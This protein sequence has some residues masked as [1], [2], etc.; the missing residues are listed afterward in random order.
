MRGPGA[1]C[2]SPWRS[3]SI[4]SIAQP[5]LR[6]APLDGPR[7]RDGCSR[8]SRRKRGVHLAKEHQPLPAAAAANHAAPATC[9][10]TSAR[11]ARARCGCASTQRIAAEARWTCSGTC[12]WWSAGHRRRGMRQ[13]NRRR[14]VKTVTTGESPPA[15]V[16][17]DPRLH[18]HVA[19]ETTR[20]LCVAAAPTLCGHAVC[21]TPSPCSTYPAAVAPG[22]T[23]PGSTC[24]PPP[25]P[26]WRPWKAPCPAGHR[27]ARRRRRADTRGGSSTPTAGRRCLLRLANRREQGRAL[28]RRSRWRGGH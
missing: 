16:E 1:A 22:P 4:T 5:E 10:A 15:R 23:Q 25:A 18:G 3:C 7:S 28:Q 13:P 27:P 11:A 17:V 9:A 12:C 24:C 2:T 21:T 20:L 14:R 8:H 6:C 19:G 26:R